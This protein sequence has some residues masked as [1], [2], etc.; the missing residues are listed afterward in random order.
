MEKKYTFE[1]YLNVV[2]ALRAPG[3]CPWDSKQT[4]E[5][6]RPY[7]VEEAYEVLD[8]IRI[9]KQTGQA[10]NLCEEL[11]DV[12][13]QV[14]LHSVIAE[15]EGYFQIEDVI[16]GGCRKMI[17]RHPH[18]F[19]E[20]SGQKALERPDWDEIKRREKGYDSPSDEI[21]SIPLEL[22]SLLRMQKVYRKK[23]KIFGETHT[24]RE[25]ADNIR[26]MLSAIEVSDGGNDGERIAA[27]LEEV[28]AIAEERGVNAEQSLADG[29]QKILDKYRQTVYK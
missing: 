28:C 20:E 16:D 26:D 29:A 10:D 8:G 25:S 13:L 3:G 15:E 5:S 21:L 4:H 22:P 14:L 9:L 1:D 11:G 17:R 6:L 27:I 2:R 7:M 19:P 18:V 12:L 23:K 24:L